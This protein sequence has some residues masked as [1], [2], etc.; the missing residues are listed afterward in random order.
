[1]AV[2]DI[3]SACAQSTL[4]SFKSAVMLTISNTDISGDVEV[5]E[6]LNTPRLVTNG[7]SLSGPV[8]DISWSPT[9]VPTI[10]G[11]ETLH[12]REGPFVLQVSVSWSP[13]QTDRCC[14]QRGHN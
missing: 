13:M 4:V 9:P 12:C 1:M 6:I 10:R 14:F 11:L 8:D 3:P 7:P 2:V 5:L